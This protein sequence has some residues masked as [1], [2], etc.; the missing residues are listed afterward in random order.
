[1]SKKNILHVIHSLDVGGAERLVCDIAK[2]TVKDI[3]NVMICC[4]DRVGALG[5]EL[6]LEGF[7]VMSLERKPGI[8]WKMVSELRKIIGEYAVDIVHAH[9][10]TSFF[11]SSLARNINE[12]PH[13]I[14]TEHGRFFPDRKS[15]KRY[16]F[17]PI[18]Q[19][20]ASEIIAISEATKE[21]MVKNDNFPKKRIK[22][23]YNGVK[24]NSKITDRNLKRRELNISEEDFVIATA[25]RLDSIKNYSMLIRMM[26]RLSVSASDIKLL[27]AGSGSEYEKLAGEIDAF[28]L[29]GHVRLLGHRRDVPDIFQASDLFVL[30]SL[31]EGTSVTLLEAMYSGLPAVVTNV[32]GNP[33]V[34]ENGVTG[35]LVNSDDDE[36]M[37]EKALIFY[38]DRSK[39]KGFGEAA[40][41][42][43]QRLFSFETMMK[44]YEDLYLKY[45]N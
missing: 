30:S 33:E 7:R 38:N 10:Y 43:A 3:F 26:K 20:F 34:V 4:L 31:S 12:R 17:N 15:T 39:L 41:M 13:I 5:E 16:I 28:N 9:Q 18:L 23:L 14:F 42:R 44:N 1:M 8:D 24:F 25:A 40:R 27:I 2:G 11:Y 37:A 6:Q 19:R 35:L 29:S 22:V 21:A 45:A 32:G 36:D